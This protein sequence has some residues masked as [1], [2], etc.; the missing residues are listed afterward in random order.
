MPKY[1]HGKQKHGID[2]A[3]FNELLGKVEAGQINTYE[4]S[5]L[6]IKSLLALFFWLGIRKTEAI[7]SKPHKYV[8][9]PCARRSA[10]IVK[11]TRAMPGIIGKDIHIEGEWLI[12]KCEPRKHGSREGALRLPLAFPF[13]DLIVQQWKL[14]EP[15]LRVWPIPEITAWRIMKQLDAKKYIH[16]FR[17]NRIT[18]L[19]SNPDISIAEICSWTG[20]TVQTIEAYMERS[21]RFIKTAAEKMRLQYVPSA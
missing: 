3:T 4:Y 18:E 9:K 8:L 11:W 10:E 7:G 15:N 14:A 12:I 1:Q 2:I 6:F 20:L 21:E 16:F 17:F 5:E 13:V 19:C